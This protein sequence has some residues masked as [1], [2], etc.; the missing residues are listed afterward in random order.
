MRTHTCYQPTPTFIPA[1]IFT[2]MH[3]LI[4]IQLRLTQPRHPF[5]VIPI[6]LPIWLLP[7]IPPRPLPRLSP[8]ILR[9]NHRS[10]RPLC[11]R[12][13]KA[14]APVFV[15]IATRMLLILS[16]SIFLSF[17]V[18]LPAER[19]FISPLDRTRPFTYFLALPG[20]I[21]IPPSPTL[22]RQKSGES[23]WREQIQSSLPGRPPP[24]WN[25]SCSRNEARQ[26]SV[27]NIEP[28]RHPRRLLRCGFGDS[29]TRLWAWSRHAIKLPSAPTCTMY[30]RGLSRK[31]IP[32]RAHSKSGYDIVRV[33]NLDDHL[34][35]CRYRMCSP[36]L[37][38]YLLGS[39]LGL[40][41]QC[42]PASNDTHVHLSSV[43][44]LCVCRR[45]NAMPVPCSYAC[46]GTDFVCA[47]DAAPRLAAPRVA[48]CPALD[49]RTNSTININKQSQARDWGPPLCTTLT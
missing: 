1:I 11:L 33:L 45:H 15:F 38:S 40:A 29:S 10:Y 2:P 4:L 42:A 43:L 23:T 37:S 9:F 8:S 19:L 31:I 47:S 16:V 46:H 36:R 35:P 5:R 39:E 3:I 32:R 25:R 24:Y 14:S 26:A 12:S 49:Q 30:I 20:F 34:A 21:F 27:M 22:F 48:P 18:L 6:S 41:Y 13:I 7:H 44:R 17:F 28:H